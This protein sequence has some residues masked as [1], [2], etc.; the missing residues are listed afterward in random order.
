[1]HAES[2]DEILPEGAGEELEVTSMEIGQDT[3]YCA[4]HHWFHEDGHNW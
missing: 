4:K 3:L 2:V 1:M